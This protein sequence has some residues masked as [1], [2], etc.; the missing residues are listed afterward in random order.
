MTDFVS[1]S[2]QERVDSATSALMQS[3]A[4]SEALGF[5][6]VSWSSHE[7]TKTDQSGLVDVN[8]LVKQPLMPVLIQVCPAHI[9]HQSLVAHGFEDSLEV[10]EWIQGT[11][12]VQL[13]DF[14]LWSWQPTRQVFDIDRSRAIHWLHLWS[15]IGSDFAAER[16]SELEEETIIL[17]MTSLLEIQPE[18]VGRPQGDPDDYWPTLDGRFHLRL[19]PEVD[20]TEEPIIRQLVET[21]YA[22]SIPWAQAVLSY[23]AMLIREETLT[24]ASR[25]RWGRM[26]DAG[27][28]DRAEALGMMRVGDLDAS[29][30]AIRNK[31]TSAN[32]KIAD[33]S[34]KKMPTNA[35]WLDEL[36]EVQDA[37]RPLVKTGR[38]EHEIAR[39]LATALPVD[40]LRQL[41]AA[42]DSDELP[43]VE[44][45]ELIENAT[46]E[47]TLTSVKMLWTHLSRSQN[48]Q[49]NARLLIEKT[50]AQLSSE[51]LE[52][53]AEMKT[54]VAALTNRFTAAVA[55]GQDLHSLRR[56]AAFVRGVLNIGL[57]AALNHCQSDLTSN[58]HLKSTLDHAVFVVTESGPEMLFVAGWAMLNSTICEC[59][60][61]ILR[62]NLPV[63][64]PENLTDL[65]ANRRYGAVQ[66]WLSQ[67][68]EHVGAAIFLVLSSV[69]NPL[70]LFPEILGA[71]TGTTIGSTARRPFET[72]Q[73]LADTLAFFDRFTDIDI[74]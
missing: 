66:K 6:N 65:L 4:P 16:L 30:A 29:L 3:A 40:A 73:D 33:S 70:P 68:E 49:A 11:K 38:E 1:Q 62:R 45:S 10:L 24:Q 53:A 22:K 56:A 27:F 14:D 34:K 28:A 9:L 12:L 57:D 26:A 17:F 54:R 60:E 58:E 64:P 51:N 74:E 8:W 23:S 15:E 25:W 46:A 35:W 63:T 44:E 31:I 13:L 61:N 39:M 36:N 19:R 42:D 50:L 69:L 52:I 37:V 32:V 55:S 7:T 72:A 21:L 59:G 18:G 2:E 41:V 67:I 20:Q 47:L 5:D 43:T 71:E 48:P